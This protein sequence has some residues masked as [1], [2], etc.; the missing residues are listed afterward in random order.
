[1]MPSTVS[2]KY[3]SRNKRILPLVGTM[4]GLAYPFCVNAAWRSGPVVLL[5]LIGVTIGLRWFCGRFSEPMNS[6]T[7]PS[8][9]AGLL[10]MIIALVDMERGPL[11]YPA[12]MSSAFAMAFGW[13]LLQKQSL[14]ERLAAPFEPSPTD[15]ARIYMRRVTCI[16]CLFLCLNTVASL[17]TIFAADINLWTFY[18]GFLTY[19]L[20]GMLFIAEYTIRQRVRAGHG[21]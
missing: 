10:T 13:S 21:A 12:F 2:M 19:V 7:L 18:N 9:V 8:L 20:M 17:Y 11:F 6:F 15:P 1:M 3:L 14:I 16:W 5:G 4:L